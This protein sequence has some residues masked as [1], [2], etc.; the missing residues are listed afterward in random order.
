[1]SVGDY[2]IIREI[3]KDLLGTVYLAQHR[4]LKRLFT[5]KALAAEFAEDFAYSA[6]FEEER[7]L[8]C[9]LDHPHIVRIH[10]ATCIDGRYFIV[11]E[12]RAD[13]QEGEYGSRILHAH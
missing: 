5:L 11:S 8:S 6:R 9:L 7:G 1:M 13:G 2:E 4:S 3:G 12:A 10:D